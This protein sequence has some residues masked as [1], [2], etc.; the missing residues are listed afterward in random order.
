[1]SLVFYL[2][3]YH[4]LLVRGDMRVFAYAVVRR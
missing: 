1:M 2:G 3:V 4:S